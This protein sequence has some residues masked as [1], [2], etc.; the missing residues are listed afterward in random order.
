R[1]LFRRRHLPDSPQ[2][3][4]GRL[5]DRR[6]GGAHAPNRNCGVVA[7][8][9]LMS[10]SAVP[11]KHIETLRTRR[12]PLQSMSRWRPVFGGVS[13]NLALGSLY[14]W[15]AVGRRGPPHHVESDDHP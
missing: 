3:D 2:H 4:R 12:A 11:W 7:A 1:D 6:H 8:R 15:M 10:K 14:A 9:E 5:G 13:M